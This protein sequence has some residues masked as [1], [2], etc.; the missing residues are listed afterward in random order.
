MALVT[1]EIAEPLA[2]VTLDNPP[3]N[4]LGQALRA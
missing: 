4:A 2:I 3:V 1:I